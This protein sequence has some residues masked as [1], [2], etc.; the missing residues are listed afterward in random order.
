MD[1][2]AVRIPD[3]A[4]LYRKAGWTKFDPNAPASTAT[5]RTAMSANALSA[6]K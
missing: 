2:T 5:S 1:N 3:R 4:N 6:E